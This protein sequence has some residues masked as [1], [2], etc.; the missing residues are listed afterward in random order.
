MVILI[1]ND[2]NLLRF[3]LLTVCYISI[4][5]YYNVCHIVVL[6]LIYN[7]AIY[8]NMYDNF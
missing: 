7:L 4:V 5:I 2:E 3:V 8:Y 1:I 6:G